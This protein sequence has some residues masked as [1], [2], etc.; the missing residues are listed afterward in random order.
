LRGARSGHSLLL[1]VSVGTQASSRRRWQA[2]GDE[3]VMATA[4]RSDCDR[5]RSG[6]P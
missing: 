3:C 5:D 2:D 4:P 1:V 6:A